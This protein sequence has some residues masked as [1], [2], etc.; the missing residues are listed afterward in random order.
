[1]YQLYYFPLNASMAPHFI[2]EELE[3]DFELVKVDRKSNAQKSKEYLALNPAGRIPTLVDNGQPIFESP[4]I[5]IHLSETNPSSNL[6]PEIGSPDRA[7]FFQWLMYL[8][9]TIQAELMVYFYPEK[10]TTDSKGAACIIQAQEERITEMFGLLDKELEG[11]DYLVGDSLSACDFFLFMLAVWADEL[12]RPPLSFKNLSG[13]LKK[14]AKRDSVV[15]VCKK[16]GLSL[17]DYE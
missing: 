17:A 6:I 14:L 12:K 11:K 15:R 9:N 2:L 1:M 10:H 3:V 13:Y 8:T 7:L 4:A 16:E 5:C